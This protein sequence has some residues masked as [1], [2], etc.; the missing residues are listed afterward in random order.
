MK[1]DRN[2]TESGRG[3]Y[4]L[5]HLRRLNDLPQEK[6]SDAGPRCAAAITL[7]KEHGILTFGNENLGEQFFAIKHKDK[8]AVGGLLGYASAVRLEIQAFSMERD[9]IKQ[10]E[11]PQRA[12][13]LLEVEK[14]ITSLLEYAMQIEH[15]AME[16]SLVANNIP[17]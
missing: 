13:K 6:P 7:L 12:L 15:E 3:K 1:L 8:F 4:A 17:G 14:E 5:V 9:L 16:A 2:T 10:M 11:G